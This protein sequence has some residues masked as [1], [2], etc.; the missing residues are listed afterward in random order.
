M[1]ILDEL[2]AKPPPPMLRPPRLLPP[3]VSKGT[4]KEQIQRVTLVDEGSGHGDDKD[5]TAEGEGCTED[6]VPAEP[7]QTPVA[8]DQVVGCS[9][10]G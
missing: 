10:S 3:D 6:E 1:T 8:H 9:R 5:D 2:L 7:V 4:G